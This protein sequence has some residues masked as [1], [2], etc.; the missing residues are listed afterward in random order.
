M[1]FILDALRKSDSEHQQ[2][3]SPEYV[4]PPSAG[5]RRGTP[6]WLWFFAALLGVNAVLLGA[7]MLRG[8]GDAPTRQDVGVAAISPEASSRAGPAVA[9][10]PIVAPPKAPVRS[11]LEETVRDAREARAAQP[12]PQRSVPEPVVEQQPAATPPRVTTV[13]RAELDLRTLDELRARGDISIPDL[14]VD[15]HVYATERAGRFLFINGRRY[16]EGDR[17]AEG[18]SVVQITDYGA[19]LEY[20]RRRFLLP[21]E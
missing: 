12:E 10:E 1:S 18:P 6:K 3:R 14:H 2:Q 16:N 21:R 15:L 11:L 9:A 19:V 7:M 5:R 4:P 13:S 8:D 17:L 20:E